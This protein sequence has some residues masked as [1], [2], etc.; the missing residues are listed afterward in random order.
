MWNAQALNISLVDLGK[1]VK[2]G[3]LHIIGKGEVKS[4]NRI[5]IYIYIYIY[6]FLKYKL[7]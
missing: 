2:I 7:A 4:Y 6:I 1:V 5:Y 3:I